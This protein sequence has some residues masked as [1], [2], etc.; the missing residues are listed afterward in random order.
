MSSNQAESQASQADS[1]TN[2]SNAP[3]LTRETIIRRAGF[4]LAASPFGNFFLAA[5]SSGLTQWWR[6]AVLFAILQTVGV[7]T[8][9]LWISSV[10]AGVMMIKG[11]RSSW[12]LTLTIIGLNLFFEVFNFSQSPDHGWFLAVASITADVLLCALIYSQVFHQK[13]EKK[14]EA[15]KVNRT[16]QA[17]GQQEFQVQFEG[18]GD[19]AKIVGMNES[20]LFVRPLGE[21]VPVQIKTRAVEVRLTKNLILKA[22]FSQMRGDEYFFRF[23]DLTEENLE[24]LRSWASSVQSVASGDQTR[25]VA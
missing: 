5:A 22:Q 4:F 25:S 17:V 10:F 8:W 3:L 2:D 14:L 21:K 19:W 1:T 11:R 23:Y 16:F 15:A 7:M 9:A 13:V 18:F 12:G 6:P 20:G 24:E